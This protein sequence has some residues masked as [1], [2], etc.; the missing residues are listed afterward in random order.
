MKTANGLLD[1]QALI[2]ELED[3]VLSRGTGTVYILADA[4]SVSFGLSDGKIVSCAFGRFQGMDAVPHI[5]AIHSGQFS[6]VD[7]LLRDEGDGSLPPTSDLIQDLK[8]AIEPAVST[9][10]SR[11]QVPDPVPAWRPDP[12]PSAG[13][14]AG[15]KLRGD[16]LFEAI[17]TELALYLG[18]MARIVAS[19]YQR[20]ILGASHVDQVRSIL[21]Q[22]GRDMGNP[23]QAQ[24]FVDKVLSRVAS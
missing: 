23:G 14:G 2:G 12:L 24:T 8:S 11:T 6:F 18:P 19:G 5:Q 9:A 21:S 4:K 22:I 10:A 3:L 13:A 15:L 16:A 20:S 17:A 1:Y 7:G